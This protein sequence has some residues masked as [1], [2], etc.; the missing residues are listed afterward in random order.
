MILVALTDIHGDAGRLTAISADLAA[1]DIVLLTGDLTHFGRREAV[2]Q[3]VD[4]VRRFN[5]HILAVPGNCD[6]REVAGY[7]TD[8]G[9]NL[10]ARH[11]IMNGLAFVGVGGSLPA[12]GRT[13]NEYDEEELGAFLQQATEGLPEDIPLI[14]VSHQPPYDTITDF[15]RIGRH[16]GSKAI[17][18]FIEIHQ[19]LI[20][21]TGHIHEGRGIDSI[22][23]T[24][25]INPGPLRHGGYA[26]AQI[27]GHQVTLEI[28]E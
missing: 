27:T 1:A 13:P 19:P 26:C 20:C 17:R 22:G 6:Q 12:P 14:L 23:R 21:F 11:V 2:T 16:V 8:E 28:R 25:I 7:L 5:S 15:A 9:I 18:H 24:Q 4:A 10:H 3:V